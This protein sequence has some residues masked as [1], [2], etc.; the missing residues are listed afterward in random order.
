MTRS[1]HRALPDID[2][3]QIRPYGSP[4]S[5][6]DAFEE[7]ASLLMRDQ[8]VE[9]PE[10]VAFL[11]F[12]NPD[13][14]R[15]GKGI[16]PNGD[17]WAWQAKYLFAFRDNEI[18][19][20]QES[21]M[22][23][24]ET[25]PNLKRYF[26]ALPYDLPAGDTSG[27]RPRRS[28]ST[29]WAEKK[30][31]W[32]SA[33]ADKGM[34]VEFVYVG[35]HDLTSEL[36]KPQH[37]GRVRYWFN[38]SALSPDD[39]K[40][41]LDDVIAKAGR[42]YSP[43]L[44][45]EVDAVSALQGLGRT[46]EYVR[47]VQVTLA[48]IRKARCSW[49]PAP[50]GDEATFRASIEASVEKLMQAE[51]AVQRYL[52]AVRTTSDLPTIVD[53]LRSPEAGLDAI[54]ELLRER[55]LKASHGNGDEPDYRYYIGNS[56]TLHSNVQKAR[57]ALYR[58]RSLL[59]SPAAQ[60]A[61]SGRLLMTGRA[62]VGKTHLFCDIAKRRIEDGLPTL[63]ALGQDFDARNLQLQIGQ[64]VE[65]DGS[66]DEVLAL[67]N[68]AGEASGHLALLMLD[69][70]NEGTNAERW[71]DELPALAAAVDRYPNVGL[72][73]SCRTEFVGPVVG[74]ATRF[75]Q[76]EHYG[77]A[78]ATSDAID[79]YTSEYNLERLTFP[80]LNPEFEN[81]LFLKLACEALATL[82]EDRFILG[83]AGLATVCNAFMDTVN[84]RL[85][86]PTRCDYDETSNLVQRLARELAIL[87][88]GPYERADVDR[89][90]ELLLPGRPWSTSLLLGLFREGVL[91]QTYD[92][93]IA[94]GY[95]RLGDVLRAVLLAEQSCKDL[96]GWYA[97]LGDDCWEEAGTIGALA[98]VA[99]EK[100]GIEI[101]D[102]FKD[103]ENRVDRAVIDAFVQSIALRAPN[104]TSDRTIRIV[105]QLANYEDW[106][107]DLW[108]NLIRVSCIP[109]HAVNAE[110]IH[111]RL[112][113]KALPDREI[114]WSE[115]LV[116][117]T[118]YENDNAIMA[119]LDWGWNPRRRARDTSP[120]SPDV[121]H[122]ATLVLGWML[123][124][125]DRR[126]RDRATKAL[127]SIGERGP[128][129]FTSGVKLFRGCDDP[130]VVERL[131]AALCAVALRASDAAVILEIAD[132]AVEL[133][134]DGW[135]LHLLTRDCLRRTSAVA[136]QRGWSGPA[137]QPPYGAKWPIKA[138]SVKTIEGM[139]K[140]PDYDYSSIWFSLNGMT[141]DF[142][143]YVL[144]PALDHFEHSDHQK[145]RAL[146]ERVIFARVLELGWTPERFKR[147]E[148]GRR[149]N[150]GAVERYGKKYQWIGLY[151][152]LGRIAD[153]LDLRDRWGDD[154]P[155]T[156]EY[157]EQLVYRDIDPCVL[158]PGGVEDPKGE[159]R[160][161]FAPVQAIFPDAPADYPVDLDGV[162]DPLD[163]ISLKSPDGIEWLSLIRHAGWT[164]ELP[165][166][167]AALDAPSLHAWMQVRGYLIPVAKAEAIRTWAVGKNWDGRW[168][169]E[170][171][172]V[173]NRLLAAHPRSPD[174][175]WADGNAEPRGP[176]DEELPANF[177]QPIAWYGGTG[178]SRGRAGIDEPTGYVPSRMLIDLLDLR[179]EDDFRWIDA[180]GLAVQDPTAGMDE[181]STL[182][183]RRDLGHRLGEAGYTLFWTVL[184]NKLRHDHT[185]SAPGPNYKW[186]SASASYLMT[187]ETVEQISANAWK[188]RRYPGGD[189]KPVEWDVRQTG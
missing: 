122:L 133:V 24:L 88:P 102:L 111:R 18:G 87:G 97:A 38:A 162:P 167:I 130:Y 56:G 85:S 114:S 78:E 171:A 82:G 83:T 53:D 120:L 7:L 91:I 188:C 5:R 96:T 181:A 104:H 67:L 36:T 77:F 148:R 76:V 132:A 155:F 156:Y 108:E 152:T 115:W 16:L 180:E 141:G 140:P 157:A 149:G 48:E 160:A 63:I 117:S 109:G 98:V 131:S 47:K 126:V 183:M 17:V 186:M 79:R 1:A 136:R 28:A 99:P 52:E 4:P 123:T 66:L 138:L 23:V 29:K 20:I 179:R 173:H 93:Q 169:P 110:W 143:R 154:E 118:A 178:T 21:V 60:A 147:I 89:I 50:E 144:E 175:D 135:P 134:A 90:S 8:L 42:R 59:R 32:E 41:R 75:P 71:I 95:Q 31:E 125:P 11:R 9:W 94:F 68:A 166:E 19:Q 69:A 12:G 30:I 84:K 70:L 121:A 27:P 185:F 124:T 103:D 39:L 61:D 127:V 14:G 150:D 35:L 55:H 129:G 165:P 74:N 176:L 40:R 54:G 177:Y 3:H 34:T 58:A 25:E 57:E 116:R 139:V 33:A 168:M 2:F 62:G 43:S 101:I 161:W 106:T 151:E 64:L 145:L 15:E 158:V 142:G 184:L 159:E 172:E 189:P 92:T 22:R 13:G 107:D 119:L 73:V 182:V 49:W 146:A 37:A 113:S 163:L 153:N 10:G 51:V 174:W 65:V 128:E 26:I 6:A 86:A 164:Q 100:L 112:S 187:I 137:W 81:P 170:N 105:E 46:S 80:T 72:V 44:H 45:V